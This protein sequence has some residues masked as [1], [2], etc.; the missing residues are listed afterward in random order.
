MESLVL[1]A[2]IVPGKLDAWRGM[3][4]EL[5]ETRRDD[6]DR[7]IRDGG[8]E[9][10]RVWH[11]RLP[12]GNDRA[13][14]LYEGPAPWKFLQRVATSDAAF[15]AWFRQGLADVHGMDLS[16]PPPPPPELAIDVG[17]A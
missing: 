11:E 10:L 13:V 4:R 8:L 3:V 17:V 12:D 6:Y 7:A 2:P 14:V 9:R 16:A 5:L 1:T 15:S